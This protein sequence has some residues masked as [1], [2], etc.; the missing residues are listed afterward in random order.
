M[1]ADAGDQA[2]ELLASILENLFQVSPGISVIRG[3]SSKGK[4]LGARTASETQWP[5]P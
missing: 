1:T 5:Q 2:T 4:A 3:T